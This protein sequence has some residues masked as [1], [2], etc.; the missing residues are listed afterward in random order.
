MKLNLLLLT[1]ATSISSFTYGQTQ[2]CDCSGPLS[3]DLKSLT[4]QNTLMTIVRTLEVSIYAR[5][6][7]RNGMVQIG[8]WN[9]Q[10]MN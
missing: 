9:F 7:K 4:N 8:E 5:L 6:T 1:L 2:E 10:K 3:K